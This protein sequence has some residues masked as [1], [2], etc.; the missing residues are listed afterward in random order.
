MYSSIGTGLWS[1]GAGICNVAAACG[2]IKKRLAKKKSVANP[3]GTRIPMVQ[4]KAFRGNVASFRGRN[5]KAMT[6]IGTIKSKRLHVYTRGVGLE[7]VIWS[8]KGE[9]TVRRASV[10]GTTTIAS[11]PATI[12]TLMRGPARLPDGVPFI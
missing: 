2:K 10:A 9:R 3:R 5:P 8:S 7:L 12:H 1:A 4:Q 11:I 6:R